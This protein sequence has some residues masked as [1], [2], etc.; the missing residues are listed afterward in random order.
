MR[1]ALG[2]EY[3]GSPYCG[4]QTQ[5]SGCSVQDALERALSQIA[6][7]RIEAQCAGR[8][9]AGV[10]ALGQVVHFDTEVRRPITAWVRGVN[11]LLPRSIAVTWAREVDDAF[12]ARYCARG[13]AYAHLLLNRPER[14]GLHHLHLGWHHHRLELD[15]MREAAAHLLGVHDFSAFR[16]AECQ[17]RSPMKELRRLD[18]EREGEMVIFHLAADAFL[19]HMV[20]NIVGCLVKVGNGTCPPGWIKVVLEGRDREH[21][22]PTYAANGL[23]LTGVE[24]D[25][26]WGLPP[27]R[28]SADSG[29]LAGLGALLMP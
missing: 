23:Y 12:H 6:D 3:D 17:A 15:P 9:D 26:R 21:A 18:I 29:A 27:G 22:A 16:A 8:T 14:P 11:T 2:L 4:W 7:H 13:R 19:H 1:L 5:P 10:H 24:Y 28:T 25:A 20:R